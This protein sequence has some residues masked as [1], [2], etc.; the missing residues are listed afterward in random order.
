MKRDYLLDSFRGLMLVIMAIDHMSSFRLSYYLYESYGFLSAAEGFFFLSGFVYGMVYQKYLGDTS[1]VWKKSLNRAKTLYFYHIGIMLFYVIESLILQKI[2]GTD[3][4]FVRKIIDQP[5]NYGLKYILLAYHPGWFNILPLY[6]V[7]LIIAPLEL[8]LIK[9]QKAWLVIII[10][11]AFWFA[12]QFDFLPQLE[13]KWVQALDIKLSSFNIFAWQIVFSLG[14]YFGFMKGR[15]TRLF[16]YRKISVILSGILVVF[17]IVLKHGFFNMN[18]D[19]LSTSGLISRNNLGT[20]RLVNFLIFVYFLAA[21]TRN[22][23]P[24]QRN[25]LSFLG[26]YSLDVYVFHIVIITHYNN[27]FNS[28]FYNSILHYIIPLLLIWVISFPA[29]LKDKALNGENL[30]ARFLL[31]FQ[32]YVKEF[33]II[34]RRIILNLQPLLSNNK[35]GNKYSDRS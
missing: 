12:H 15:G 20:V 34:P 14:I 6:I 28:L 16:S 22:I 10:S 13:Q 31:S 4:E 1:K 25:Y 17:L 23:K 19:F 5:L 18:W 27:I 30:I 32:L 3:I 7:F 11:I 2:T 9:N 21:I 26:Q 33:Y 8:I 29:V 24:H 35:K